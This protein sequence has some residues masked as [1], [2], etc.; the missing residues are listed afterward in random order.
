MKVFKKVFGIISSLSLMM[1]SPFS[2]QGQPVS[3]EWVKQYASGGVAIDITIDSI[4]NVYVTGEGATIK[5]DTNGNELWVKGGRTSSIAVDLRDNVYV[6]GL[7]ATT[8][9]DTNGNELWVKYL[10]GALWGKWLD[11]IGYDCRSYY[12]YRLALDSMG[13]VYVTGFCRFT[14]NEDMGVTIKYDTNGNELWAREAQRQYSYDIT[15]DSSGNVY[16][17]GRNYWG[18][19]YVLTKYDTNGNVLWVKQWD[20]GATTA[21]SMG[22]IYI[23]IN[24]TIAK[25]DIDENKLWAAQYYGG[26]PTGI[27]IDS[28][29]KIYVTGTSNGNRTTVKY[30]ADGNELWNKQYNVTTSDYPDYQYVTGI[31]LDS[32]GNIYVTGVSNND[33]VTVKY[34][35]DNGNKLWEIRYDGG[36]YD[37]PMALV[38]DSASN[39]YVTGYSYNYDYTEIKYLTIKYSQAPSTPAEVVNAVD[40]MLASGEISSA[41]IAN[42]IIAQL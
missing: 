37:Q 38:V 24:S 14:Y 7:S 22:N 9:Y 12:M 13:N 10:T 28:A 27:I 42:T 26:T 40:T 34:D 11:N 39:V 32:R 16:V 30:D 35:T 23:I 29:G 18:G 15:A 2:A 41:A 5:Y 36:G 3:E 20:N 25:Y 31:T 17:S 8:K 21:D 4:D 19:T 6:T 1:L 33:Y